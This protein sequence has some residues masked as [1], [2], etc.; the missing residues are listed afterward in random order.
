M[1]S[2]ARK[3][4]FSSFSSRKAPGSS[5]SARQISARD[6]PKT[7]RAS[8]WNRRKRQGA[9]FLWSGTRVAARN[10]NSS[11]PASGPG[12]V[13]RLAETE[14]R[15]SKRSRAGLVMGGAE[16]DQ[17]RAVSLRRRPLNGGLH[18]DRSGRLKSAR[19]PKSASFTKDFRPLHAGNGGITACGR[20]GS[21][22]SLCGGSAAPCLGSCSCPPLFSEPA[23]R[24]PKPRLYHRRT[25]FALSPWS[26]SMLR[27][28]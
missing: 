28:A 2:G 3:K 17:E 6:F 7:A 9:S 14:R 22:R 18:R 1:T 16:Q 20:R 23:L 12:P 27:A 11:S 19:Y 26:C 21:E 24:R 15:V 25:T 13:R 4:R 8:P 10:I 5:S